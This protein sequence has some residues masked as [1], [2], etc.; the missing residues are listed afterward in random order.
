[1]IPFVSVPKLVDDDNDKIIIIKGKIRIEFDT[2]IGYHSIEQLLWS[3][4]CYV[5]SQKSDNVYIAVGYTDMM[6]GIDGLD[7]LV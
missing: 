6:K 2:G 1:M 3:L 4:L 5:I 7:F